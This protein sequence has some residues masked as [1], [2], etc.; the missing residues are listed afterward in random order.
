VSLL[1]YYRHISPV[2]KIPL[3]PHHALNG[4]PKS[5]SGCSTVQDEEKSEGRIKFM[6]RYFP[7]KVVLDLIP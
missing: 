5:G 1:Q 4:F 6:D 7:T 2:G 3:K